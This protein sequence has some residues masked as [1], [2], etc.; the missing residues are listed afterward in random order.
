MLLLRD[1]PFASAEVNERAGD[2]NASHEVAAVDFARD[3]RPILQQHCQACHG[4]VKRESGL[5]LLSRADAL[6]EADSGLRAILPG[7]PDQSELMR[8]VMSND[9]DR[10][11]AR[12]QPLAAEQIETLR[13]WIAA[14]AEW[15]AH[16]SF[17]PPSAPPLPAVSDV[18]WV[19]NPIDRFVLTRLEAAGLTPSPE[20]D[21]FTLIRRLYLDL[22]G[23]PP[24]VQEVDDFLGDH[25]PE[26]YQQLVDRLLASPQFG[27][28]WG[29]HWLDQA[30]YADTDGYEVDKPRPDAWRWRDWVIDAINADMP[31]DRFTVLQIAGDLLPGAGQTERLATAFHRQSLTNREGGI[32]QEEFR[33]KEAVDRVNA[34]GTVWLGLTVGCAQCHNHPYDALAQREYY[35]LFAF[36]N[37]IDDVSLM[38]SAQ[39]PS[40]GKRKDASL[41]VRVVAQARK[42]RPT[43]ILRRGDFLQPQEEVPPG[44][45]AA[46]PALDPRQ[47]DSQPDRLDLAHW[48][49]DP[50]NPL[51]PR[52]TVNQIWLHLFGQALVRTPDDFGTRGEPPTHP[53]QLDWLAARLVSDG[54]SRKALV[55]LIVTSAA[56]RQSSRRRVELEQLDPTNRLLHRQNRRRVEAEVLR[57]LHL[58]ASGL[59][60]PRIGGPSVFPPLPQEVAKLSFRS[61]YEWQASTEADRY[62]RGMYT[63]FKR[64]LPHPNLA[65]FDCPDANASAAQRSVSNTPAQALATLNEESFLEAACALGRIM[66]ELDGDIEQILTCGFRRC[67]ARPPRA[68]ETGRLARLFETSR[69]WYREH[70]A[71]AMELVGAFPP[72]PLG[73]GR[74]EGAAGDVE[75]SPMLP[76]PNPLPQGEGTSPELAA[77]IVTAGVLMNLDEF[78]TRE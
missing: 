29:R 35:Q 77:W 23:L 61:N 2:S 13:R 6:A 56:Y 31:F 21:R 69:A 64:T 44:G 57:D 10:M 42:H 59:L 46:L 25:A 68:E 60:A 17:D 4:G 28:R 65:T 36:L 74:G 9:D 63:H 50:A 67:L 48:L 71:A 18:A 37:N 27:E 19:R 15:P 73:E 38:L 58:A 76:L 22:L 47:P 30:R 24:P 32:D 66:A 72:L 54:W 1:V 55:R 34:I 14:G 20:A 41:E 16:W 43:H 78:M 45:L 33:I 3:V 62:R 75:L 26:A 11:P 8:R 40:S 53:E 39:G 70:P 5:S 51:A 7:S 12:G 49:V 52:V